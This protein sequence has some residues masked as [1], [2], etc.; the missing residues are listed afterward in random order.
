MDGGRRRLEGEHPGCVAH[1]P[2]RCSAVVVARSG[3]SLPREGRR[4]GAVVVV[5]GRYDDWHMLSSLGVA[6]GGEEG[7]GGRKEEGG[8]V[9]LTDDWRMLPSP[10]GWPEEA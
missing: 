7:R 9:T 8:G 6:P 1:K 3:A 2:P 10:L 5:A 4:T